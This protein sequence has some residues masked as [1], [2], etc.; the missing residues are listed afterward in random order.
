MNCLVFLVVAVVG[1]GRRR[2]GSALA[3]RAK[4][5]R[6][7]AQMTV[8]D[9]LGQGDCVAWRTRFG[10]RVHG[11]FVRYTSDNEALIRTREGHMFRVPVDNPTVMRVECAPSGFHLAV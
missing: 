5:S 3:A 9:Q 7:D 2:Y 8:I 4:L 6:E 1:T 11:W 10:I